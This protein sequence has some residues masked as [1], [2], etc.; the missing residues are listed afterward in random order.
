MERRV[1]RTVLVAAGLTVLAL[2]GGIHAGRGVIVER[3]HIW[4]L[5]SADEATRLDAAEKLAAMMSVA[6]ASYLVE[7]VEREAGLPPLPR[8]G[9]E[10][11]SGNV[12]EH[13]SLGPVA[14]AL[15]RIGKPAL[16]AIERAIEQGR[17]D[18]LALRAYILE[19]ARYQVLSRRAWLGRE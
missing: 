15:Y 5:R 7:L 17:P 10:G 3:W 9:M 6:A 16:P 18:L 8:G 2:A 11:L 13:I 4:R 19:P 1:P 12:S 14:E